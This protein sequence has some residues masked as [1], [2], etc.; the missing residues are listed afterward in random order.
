M[1]LE[2]LKN[3]KKYIIEKIKRLGCEDKTKSFMEIML[4]ES[5]YYDGTVY[6]LVM[7]VYNTNFRERAKRSGHKL[8][9]IAGNNEKRTYSIMDKKFLYND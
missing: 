6:E 1:K 3:R 2:Q 4:M 9:E 7:R 5:E 8:A